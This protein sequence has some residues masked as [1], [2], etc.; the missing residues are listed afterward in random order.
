[1]S[2]SRVLFFGGYFDVIFYAFDINNCNLTT[3]NEFGSLR[4]P[5]SDTEKKGGKF[6]SFKTFKFK[7]KS[8]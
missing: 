1:M 5:E 3:L 4:F 7:D 8:F 6:E 2:S